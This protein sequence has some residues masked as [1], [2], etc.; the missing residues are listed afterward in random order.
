PGRV[1]LEPRG[2]ADRYYALWASADVGLDPFPYNGGVT[3]P[4][5]L[6][7]GVPVV[8]LAGVGCRARQGLSVLGAFGLGDWVA[9]TADAYAELA[10]RKAGDLAGLAALRASLRDRLRGSPVLD[11]ARFARHLEEA[12]RR[13]WRE[14]A[15]A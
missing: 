2:P 6:W 14:R 15:G 10:A 7:M 8:S 1:R 3:T 13:M 12:Y 9:A 5:A 11:A 4:D